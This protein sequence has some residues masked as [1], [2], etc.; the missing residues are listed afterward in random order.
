MIKTIALILVA[1]L[2]G[3]LVY[4]STKPDVFQVQR[5]AHIKAS[6]D[7][8]QPLIGDLHQFNTWNP[9]NKKD[10]TMQSSY[11]GPGNSPGSAY[12]FKGNKD[13]GSGSI[14]ITGVQP[15]K[16]DMALDMTEPFACH[17]IIEFTLQPQG[18]G[19]EVTWAMHGPSKLISKVMGVVFDMDKMVGRDFE[20]GLSSLKALAEAR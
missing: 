3:L 18:D 7:K 19:T 8:I 13:V 9:Y 11:E 10:P 1:A 20:A 6:P 5:S 14:S 15:G 17:N 4:A 16:V 12:H 2:A